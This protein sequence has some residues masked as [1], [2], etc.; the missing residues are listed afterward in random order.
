MTDTEHT[1]E[2]AGQSDHG[3]DRDPEHGHGQ[4]SSGEALGPVDV[5]TWAYAIA[6]SVL[7]ILTILAL[8]VAG[9]A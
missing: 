4:A 6:G 8:Y 5:T 1:P 7:A 3:H 9:G 2:T